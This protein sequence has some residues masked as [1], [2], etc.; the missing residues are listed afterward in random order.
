[1]SES[2]AE[3]KP[4]AV[5][6]LAATAGL[7]TGLGLAAG[8][9]F[10][11]RMFLM[12]RA[13]W[14]DPAALAVNL[15]EVDGVDLLARLPYYK[16]SAPA[17][18]LI[19]SKLLGALF[20]YSEYALTILPLLL[21]LASIALF[22]RLS[23]DLLGAAGAPLAL[24]PLCASSTAVYY[25][26]EFKQYSADLFF[27]VLALLVALHL[28]RSGFGG[29]W[30]AAFV[31]VGVVG[32]WFS[33]P[34]ILVVAGAGLAL[35]FEALRRREARA[36]G[37]LAAAVALIFG[38]FLLL[39]LLQIRSTVAPSL[40]D[41]W[42]GSF[43]VL[44]ITRDG[45]AWWLATATGYFQYPLGFAGWL[46]MPLL[47]MA[48]GAA[49]L[50]SRR[51]DRFVGLLLLLPMLVLLVVA[52]LGRYPLTTGTHDVHSRFTLFTAPFAFL[53]I[54]LGF[55]RIVGAMRYRT[56]ALVLI[57][58]L[59]VFPSA[60]RMIEWPYFIQQEMRQL[61]AELESYR[62]PEEPVYVYRYAEPAFRFYTRHAP[63]PF[64]AGQSAGKPAVELPRE[65]EQLPRQG[66]VWVVLAHDF[67]RERQ[68]V[69][70][71]MADSC[72]LEVVGEYPGA[73]LLGFECSSS[74][75]AE[76][77]RQPT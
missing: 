15:V 1:M 70:Q 13:L 6:R 19:A 18:F 54:G 58:S 31:G 64:I 51:G 75:L 4:V 72:S 76:A 14:L 67:G 37:Q 7:L 66:R 62:A 22:A 52:A 73:R 33:L 17:G 69:E 59:L 57:A 60:R 55:G 30:R 20:D 45:L 41:Y 48:A 61:V 11:L 32:A 8:V 63:I 16:Q 38:H 68:I 23:W 3:S 39:Y 50:V 71:A 10:R 77:P 43:P 21:S 47:G 56:A 28:E 9:L 74:P 49:A 44:P 36:V 27:S 53:L 40:F 24:L 26:G 5:T 12:N 46:A 25:A 29:R 35:L 42:A 34:S 65:L 2:P